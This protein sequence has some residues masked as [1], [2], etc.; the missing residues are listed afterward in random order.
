MNR[1][2]LGERIKEKE[3]TGVITLLYLIKDYKVLTTA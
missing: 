1:Y 2:Y 3:N